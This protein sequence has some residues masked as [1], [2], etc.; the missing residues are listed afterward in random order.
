M[1]VAYVCADPG[2]PVFGRKGSS[3]H[4]QEVIRALIAKD[5]RVELFATRLEGAPP[6]GLEALLVHT[7]PPLPI[8]A[9]GA[10]LAAREQAALQANDGLRSVLEDEGPFDL[11]Y[12]RYS[13]W[14]F[15]AME[16][17]RTRGVPG[18]LEVNAPL[19]EE[20]A[21]HRGLV[22]RAGAEQ[23]AERLFAAATALVAVSRQVAAYLQRYPTARGRIHVVPNGVN[24]NRFPDCLQPSCPASPGMF[25]VGFVGSLKPWHGLPNLVEA[26]AMLHQRDPM[27]RL[28]IVGDGPERASVEADVA[29]RGLSE[30]VHFTGAVDPSD[31]PGLLASMDVAVAPYPKLP[32]FYFSPLKVYEYMAAGLP[33]VASGIGQL[34]ELIDDEVNGLLCP[35]GNAVSLAER[36]DH[37]R[38]EP[39][40]RAR[41]GRAARD[42]VLRDHTWETVARRIFCVAGID[43]VA[44]TQVA[45]VSS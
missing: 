24:P 21:E 44:G 6:Q 31:V 30:A 4:V 39:E 23:V 1:R 12:E 3:I 29:A 17:A 40:L 10:K 16:Y 42:T 32:D 2:V 18:L 20:Q 19:I 43:A 28:L 9:S 45:E 14:S 41:L 27:S 8:R 37:L 11:I 33:V 15:A 34:V 35:P 38:R 5:A 22:D 25:T 36:L 26:F 7:L 13:L